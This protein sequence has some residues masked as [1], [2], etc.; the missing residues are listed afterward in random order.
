MAEQGLAEVQDLDLAG[1]LGDGGLTGVT[2]VQLF[3]RR[4]LREP[5]SPV[6]LQGEG[7]GAAGRLDLPQ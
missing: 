3:D 6:Q 1:P 5:G 7:R 2:E 4:F